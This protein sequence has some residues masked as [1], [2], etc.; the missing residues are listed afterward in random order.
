MSEEEKVLQIVKKRKLSASELETILSSLRNPKPQTAST[1]KDHYGKR[2]KIGVFSDAHIGV[3][4]FDEPF[5]RYM[6]QRFKQEKVERILNVGDILEGMSGREGHVY[7]LTHIGLENQI[8]YAIRLLNLLPKVPILGINGNHDLWAK[9]KRDI[10]ANV[11]KMIAQ[12]VENYHHLGDWEADILANGL[13]IR[14]FHPADGTA[15]A[16]SYKIQKYV[17]QLNPGTKPALILEGHYHKA[18]YMFLRGIHCFE[19]GTLSGQT[20]WMRGK[21]IQANKGFWI[22][23]AE[24]GKKGRLGRITPEFYP[25]YK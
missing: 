6:A 8:D 22:L 25:G 20:E 17:E 3:K 4:E 5:F 13:R 11:G 21:K 7:Q 23:D 14:L 9:Q 19:C 16:I 10:G 24:F 2:I 1:F 15:Y 12:R 18:L